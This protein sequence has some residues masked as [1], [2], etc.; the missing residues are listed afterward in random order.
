MLK[1]IMMTSHKIYYR[2][3]RARLFV[4]TV[5]ILVGSS[6]TKNFDEINTP[7][8]QIT[9]DQLDV[10]TVG[11]ALAQAQYSGMMTWYQVSHNLYA[12]EWSQFFTIIHPNFPSAN[13]TE[14]GSWSDPTFTGIYTNT[15]WGAAGTQL[16]LVEDFTEENNL[17]VE[18]AIAKVWKVQLFH[19][20]TDYW[21]PII[22][23]QF[24]NGETSVAY[25]SQEDIYRS[26]FQT[27]DEVVTVFQNNSGEEAFGTNDLVYGGNVDQYLKWANS[28]R[29]RLAIRIAYA[30]PSLAQQEA[31]KAISAPGGVITENADSALLESTVNNINKL[32]SI[33]YHTEFVVSS[34]MQSLL[35]GYDDPRL[36]VYMQPCCGRLQQFE[37]EGY[38]GMRNGMPSSDR[39]R[40][41]E[42]NNSF[43]GSKW[44]PIAD[45]GT[46]EPDRL[47]EAAE[48]YFLRAEGALRGWNMGGT[49][50]DLYESGIRASLEAR[51][52]ATSDVIDAYVVSTNTPAK[53]L[54]YTGE[55]DLYDSPPVSDIPVLYQEAGSF[56]TRLE[57]IITQKWL[58]LYPMND[59]EAWTERRRTGYPRGYAIIESLNPRVSTTELVRRL[60]FVPSEY[61]NNLEE[62]EAAVSLL[63]GPDENDTRVWWDAKPLSDYPTPTDPQ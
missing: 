22:Y 17:T 51:T 61:T 34:T 5:T 28:L 15:R 9:I 50:K 48:V 53:P 57:Q 14:V 11:S 29:L 59:W 10:K 12:G 41:L 8:D 6:C 39:G 37:G 45:G 25:D 31:E 47:M 13:F 38:V 35:V 40:D 43:V 56:E 4:L 18:N 24:G 44:L 7:K 20:I 62:T 19:R 16:K 42:Q 54:T 32:S 21:G 49:A 30:D 63:G 1:R 3:K 2:L 55:A 26:F 33:T 52:D 36:D 27:L 23:S 60:T 58:S 46:N